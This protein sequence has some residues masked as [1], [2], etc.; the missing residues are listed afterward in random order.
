[1]GN[2]GHVLLRSGNLHQLK[3][4]AKLKLSRRVIFVEG[5]YHDGWG[6]KKVDNWFGLKGE[7]RFNHILL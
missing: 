2:H 7:P 6:T 1:M 5:D 3:S 4:G